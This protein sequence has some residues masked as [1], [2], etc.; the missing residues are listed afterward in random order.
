MNAAYLTTQALFGVGKNLTRKALVSYL[1]TKGSSMSSAALVPLG[2]SKTTHEGY[3]GF[4]IGAYDASSVLK[5][6]GTD[7]VVYTT[8]SGT[9]PVT[10]STY[11]RP[12]MPVDALPKG[13]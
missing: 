9:G 7:R 8:D 5:P 4:W 13:A 10:V 3:T 2:Y 1:E 11:K 12:A 6:V